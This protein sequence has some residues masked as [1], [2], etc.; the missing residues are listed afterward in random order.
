MK[1]LQIGLIALALIFSLSGCSKE[2][3]E[4][5]VITPEDQSINT[6]DSPDESSQNKEIKNINAV[7]NTDS[8]QSI[9]SVLKDLDSINL[10]EDSSEE[11]DSI[12]VGDEIDDL[13]NIEE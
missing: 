1:K 6:Q 3:I 5:P 2:K 4:N 13:N 11:L 7:K 8:S 12:E 9:D 10:D